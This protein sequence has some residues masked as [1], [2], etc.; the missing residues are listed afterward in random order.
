MPIIE[1]HRR[2]RKNHHLRVSTDCGSRFNSEILT[3]SLCIDLSLSFVHL[4]CS[5]LSAQI[6]C[7][8]VHLNLAHHILRLLSSEIGLAES[9]ASELALL[10]VNT[11]IVHA[12]PFHFLN[13]LLNI[14]WTLQGSI[15][16]ILH[17]CFLS[18][19][20]DLIVQV[21]IEGDLGLPRHELA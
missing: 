19:L 4:C 10:E 14:S 12:L 18:V 11:L 9:A 8:L 1:A 6:T 15:H 13:Q 17:N 2:L 3:F 5:I 16:E 7:V 20:Q 21:E